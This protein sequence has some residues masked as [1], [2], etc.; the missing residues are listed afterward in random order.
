MKKIWCGTI[1]VM[2]VVVMLINML[3]LNALAIGNNSI[4]AVGEIPSVQEQ[5]LSTD[6][7]ESEQTDEEQMAYVVEEDVSKRS[8]F[9]KEFILS[10][11]LRIATIYPNSVHYEDNGQWKEIDNTLTAKIIDGQNVYANTSG[12]WDV[13]FPQ[14]LNSSNSIA[15]TKDGYTVSFGMAGEI[16]SN[17]DL[18]VASMD[19]ELE[20]TSATILPT[21]DITIDS[22]AQVQQIDT[23]TAK[24]E[25]EYAE[26]VPDK[27]HSR[28][29]YPS[30]YTNTNIAY[31]LQSNQVKES[32]ILQSFDSGLMGYR[33]TL[34]TGELIPILNDDQSIDLCDPNTDDIVMTMPA[35][36]MLDA[37][38]EYCEDIT[39]SLIQSGNTYILSYYLPVDWLSTEDRAWPVI[40]DPVISANNARTNIQDI[41]VAEN[42]TESNNAAR[43]KCGYHPT[44]GIC[45]FYLRFKELPELPSSYVITEAKLTLTKDTSSTLSASIEVHKVDAP[46]EASQTTWSSKPSYHY[47]IE[48]VTTVE[49]AGTY[50]WDVTDI[51]FGWYADTENALTNNTGMLFK[52][53]DTVE[54]A[55]EN[56]WQ[57]LCSSDHSTSRPIL[58]ITYIDT[59]GLESYWDTTSSSVGRAGTGYVQPYSGN[60][61]W[62]HTDIGFDG[63]LMPVSI[64]HIYNASDAVTGTNLFGMSIGWRTNYNQ[65]IVFSEDGTPIWEDGDGTAHVF[66]YSSGEWRDTDDLGLTFDLVSSSDTEYEI[67]DKYGNIS[68]F[69]SDG[70]LIAQINN[71]ASSSKITIDYNDATPKQI[72]KITDGV[73]RRYQF[74]Y[75]SDNLLDEIAY[76]G[77]NTDA[78]ASPISSI[79]FS[80][81]SSQLTSIT[82]ADEKTTTFAYTSNNLLSSATDIDGYKIT[83]SYNTLDAGKPSRVVS[84]AESAGGE[85]GG[86][87]TLSY[88]FNRTV[89][90][91]HNENSQTYFFNCCGNTTSIQDSEGRA[92]FYQYETDDPSTGIKNRLLQASQQQDTVVNLIKDHNFE[93]GTVWTTGSSSST[94]ESI[95][96]SEGEDT[97]YIGTYSLL[98]EYSGEGRGVTGASSGTYSIPA[99]TSVTFSAYVKLISGSVNIYISGSPSGFAQ[100]DTLYTIGEWTRM[101][102]T[103]S[104]DTD[105]TVQVTL[106]VSHIYPGKAYIDCVQLEKAEAAS[107]YNLLENAD[108]SFGSYGWFSGGQNITENETSYS[109]PAPTLSAALIE[110]YDRAA[111]PKMI[112]QTVN[113]SGDANDTFVFG[114]WMC[115]SSLS[116][117]S[118]V[119]LFILNIKNTDGTTTIV[120]I[121]PNPH[122]PNTG[123]WQYVLSSIT[124]TKPYSSVTFCIQYGCDPNHIY[125]DGLQLFREPFAETYIYNDSDSNIDATVDITGNRTEYSYN[126]TN[127]LTCVLEPTGV[128]TSYTYDSY[129]RVTRI[130]KEYQDS[131]SQWE[132]I[133]EE[134]FTYDA[135]GN[136]TEHTYR[137]EDTEQTT[138]YGYTTDGNFLSWIEDSLDQRTYYG[139]NADNSTLEWIQYPNDTVSTRQTFEYDDETF[140]LVTTYAETA[141]LNRMYALYDYTND[142]LTEI[143]TYSSLYE[144]SYNSWGQRTGVAVGSTNLAAYTYSDDANRYLIQLDYG[145]GDVVKYTYDDLGRVTQESYYESGDEENPV[146]T[147][148]YTYDS[149]GALATTVDSKTGLS[150][151]TYYDTVGRVDR[152]RNLASSYTHNLYY[153]YD[154]LGQLAQVTETYRPTS[155]TVTETYLTSYA[156]EQGRVTAIGNDS[157]TS[158]N[159]SDD[160]YAF[161][162]YDG[163]DRVT[164]TAKNYGTATVLGETWTYNTL[165]QVTSLELEASGLDRSYTYTYD[166][167]GNITSVKL[168][169]KTTTYVYDSQNQLIRENNQEANKTWVWAYDA[170]GNITSKKEYAY[171][172][173]VLGTATDTVTYGYDTAWGDKLISYDGTTISYDAIGNPLS[174]G[175]WNYVW[176]QGRQLARMYS[177][178]TNWYFHYDSDGMRYQRYSGGNVYTYVYNGSQL[179]RMT[180][181]SNT[182][183]FTYGADGTPLTINLNGTTY[184][185]VTNLQGDVVAILNSSGTMVVSYTYDAWGQLLGTVDYTDDGLGTLNPLRYRGYVY[186]IETGLYYLQ[187]RYYNPATGRFINVDAVISNIGGDL[188]GYNLYSY[189]FNNPVMLY[190]STGHFP[191]LILAAVLLF[192]PVGGI[193]TQAVT[194]VASYAGMAIASIWD[195]DV[196]SDMNAIGWNP[197]NSDAEA[198]VNSNKVSFYKGVPVFRTNL[199]RS[200]SFY[201]I[202]LNRESSTDTLKHERGHNSQA[203]MMG[204]ANFGLMV[205]LPSALEW[206]SHSYYDRPWEIT[207]D[208][209]GGVEGRSHTQ[210][211]INKGYW[212]LGVSSLLGPVG[213]IFL[214]GEY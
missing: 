41:T 103:Y 116:D 147:V 143:E 67:T 52:T 114:G 208:V 146:R 18:V 115:K 21:I 150:T 60:L 72:S 110:F 34:N 45:R 105:S 181:R 145:N 98:S 32:I 169:D 170:A 209:F 142:R 81:T 120:S 56:N 17:G 176:E 156:Y 68:Q 11:G 96:D 36:F 70:Y 168:G 91:D 7:L 139:Y 92:T 203:M 172:T 100:S 50:E 185:Y 184:Y 214:F 179:S 111:A 101:E 85:D 8:E 38:D 80:Y 108:I 194:S 88:T 37:N 64:S 133:S 163:F 28:L 95:E 196:R 127:D 30:V 197:F 198:T 55:Q 71:Q 205:G 124:T 1:S 152:Q 79:S 177:S 160:I 157:G 97:A 123:D 122:I 51:A 165:N 207:A 174:D 39:V 16:R 178:S 4:V 93:N 109:W 204:V 44:L 77:T 125:V 144:L 206:S 33:Y 167:N 140:R 164:E 153:S 49:D 9:Y 73:G 66:V 89:L 128:R 112:T 104:N 202:F 158:A 69:D 61:T 19:S 46:W 211:D 42:G 13:Y 210:Q 76:Y 22:S 27:L 31:D 190:D 24:A 193:A 75:G 58:T 195:E 94:C 132:E 151:K 117:G 166:G 183:R 134:T 201:A 130:L 83:Y 82:Y 26:I 48:D 213:Y 131:E 5:I 119:R 199:D 154:A 187:S 74:V 62:V 129:H 159:Y 121:S 173:G 186:D 25:A 188:R 87:T 136:V 57:Q 86:A 35:P 180:Y 137:A 47:S 162:T 99:G 29:I 135:Y 138:A 212:Y 23:A 40:L 171:S 113:I 84:I 107:R 106:A 189:C 14:R 149:T 175:T 155:S 148:T 63:N 78:D 102:V 182:M 12:L 53:S 20:A 54:T 200:G 141:S 118:G 3:P 65:R 161:Y 90:T 126:E 191:W 43:V 10:N 15:I 2:L 6:L 59:N 192:T